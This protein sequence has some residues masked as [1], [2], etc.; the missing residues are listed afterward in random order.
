[1][2]NEALMNA[3]TDRFE[4]N[5]NFLNFLYDARN[6]TTQNVLISTKRL[7]VIYPFKITHTVFSTD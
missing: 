4:L 5:N 3:I 6:E 7:A 2:L 1:M